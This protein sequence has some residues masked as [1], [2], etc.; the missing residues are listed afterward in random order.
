VNLVLI[1]LVVTV[2]GLGVAALWMRPS[3]AV[4][5]RGRDAALCLAGALVLGVACTQVR[6][7][8]DASESRRNS[9]PEAEQ[10]A[11]EAITTP[12]TIEVHLAPGDGRRQQFDAQ[13]LAKL[14]RTM[15]HVRVVYVAK[16]ST[17]LYES[18][19]PGY[20]EIWYDLG[21]RRV[22]SHQVT[23]EN[24]LETVMG[25]AGIAPGAD[26]DDEFHGHPLNTRPMGASVVFYGIWPIGL[27]AF[28][29]GVIRKQA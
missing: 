24:V 8:W 10:E 11:L 7:S 19:D 2:A 17:G 23:D 22:M 18:A 4:G 15:R 5:R 25:L 28:G 29:F 21:G 26:T 20:G 16:S 14:K 27:A 3:V 13:A 1:A 12:L 9:F 6:G